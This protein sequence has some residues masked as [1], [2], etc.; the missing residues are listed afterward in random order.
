ME[1]TVTIKCRDMVEALGLSNLSSEEKDKLISEISDVAT[2]K[3]ILR[4][5]GRLSEEEAS[6]LNQYVEKGNMDAVDKLLNEKV[7][8]FAN[9]VQEEI[10][11]LQ[12]EMIKKVKA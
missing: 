12:E 7:P 1:K 8:D 10:S 9:I 11:K 2:G 6:T 5:I 3:I 4:V